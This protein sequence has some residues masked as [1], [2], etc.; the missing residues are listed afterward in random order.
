MLLAALIAWPAATLAQSGGA[1]CG[2]FPNQAAAQAAYRANPAALGGLD[3]DR[4][5]VVCESLPCPC[6]GVLSQAQNYVARWSGGPLDPQY[7]NK[8]KMVIAEQR[9]INASTREE[10]AADLEEAYAAQ[11]EGKVD[12]PILERRRKALGKAI[13][14]DNSSEGGSPDPNADLYQ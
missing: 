10:V 8:I 6:D 3:R 2:S 5:G 14:R 7:V 13:R 1:T 11:N 9:R 12:Q 4:D